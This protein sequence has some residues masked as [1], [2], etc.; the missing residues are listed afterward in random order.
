[1][2]IDLKAL[3]EKIR[4]LQMIRQLASDPE[5]APLLQDV[6]VGNGSGPV[7]VPRSP[8]D[9]KGVRKYVFKNVAENGDQANYQTSREIAD[10]MKAGGYKFKSRDHRLTVKEQLRELEKDGLV[11]KAGLKEDGS[12]LW[13]KK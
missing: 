1:M 2:T 3:D 12:A 9:L 4:K 8:K 10:R 13:R 6:I 11:E 7:I 5:L